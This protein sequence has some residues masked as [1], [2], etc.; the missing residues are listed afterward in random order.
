MNYPPT[1]FRYDIASREAKIYQSPEISGFKADDYETKEVFYASKDGTRV[2][3]FLVY[4]R[5]L[6]LDGNNPVLLSGYGGFNIVEAPEFNAL[7]LALLEQGRASCT[8]RR[9]CEAGENMGKNGTKR[10]QS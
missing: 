6:K 4:R 1:I 10:D 7:R 2:P 5:G 3:M 8:R 9:T